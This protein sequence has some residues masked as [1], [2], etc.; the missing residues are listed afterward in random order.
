M[1]KKREAE[2]DD[3]R[4]QR[5]AKNARDRIKHTS[6]EAEALDAAVRR[7]IELHGA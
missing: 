6:T 7:S 3:H 5:L 1:R 2:S 4:S